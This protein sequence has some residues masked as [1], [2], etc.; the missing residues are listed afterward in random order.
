MVA[1]STPLYKSLSSRM[2]FPVPG[3]VRVRNDCGA[4]ICCGGSWCGMA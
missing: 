2:L 1:K 3:L 4:C